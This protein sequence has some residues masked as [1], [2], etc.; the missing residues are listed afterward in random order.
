MHVSRAR[1]A[2]YVLIELDT[3][4]TISNDNALLERWDTLFRSLKQRLIQPTAEHPASKVWRRVDLIRI[5]SQVREENIGE[6]RTTFPSAQDVVERME[7]IAWLTPLELVS[8]SDRKIAPKMY[9]LDMEATPEGMPD[10]LELLQG[11]QP[12]GVLSYFSIL[13]FY[14]LTTQV[15]SYAHIGILQSTSSKKASHPPT[16]KK[17]TKS[18]SPTSRQRNLLGS[19]AFSYQGIACYTTRRDRTLVPGI[20][21]REM[22]PHT[23]LRMTTLE[24]T[25]LDTLLHPLRCGGESVVF[26]AWQNALDRLNPDR[27]ERHLEKIGR[28]DFERRTGA[29]ID[30]MKFKLPNG[31]LKRRLESRRKTISKNDAADSL[32][33]LNGFRYDRTLSDWRVSIP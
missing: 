6:L 20:Q 5:I 19:L 2:W 30:L 29:M 3:K 11:F 10:P 1:H 18:S 17:A 14:E 8:S 31:R 23:R 7:K 22:G 15:P 27:L 28:E 26:E 12:N 4:R 21:T 33:L 25:L 9:L 13:G 16:K 24:Q 32:P